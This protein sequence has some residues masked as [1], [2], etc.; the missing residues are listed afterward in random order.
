MAL[1]HPL[2]DDPIF[3]TIG[4]M[5]ASMGAEAYVIGGFVRDFY[6]RRPCKDIDIVVTGSGIALAELLGQKLGVN[7]SVFKNFGTAM[8]H[9][10]DKELEF[11]GARKESY[12][13]DSRKPIV[14]D[15]T[16]EDDQNRRDFTVNAMAFSLQ[17]A[18]FGRLV[19]PFNGLEDLAEC[20]IRTPL[21]PDT[22]FSDDPL[23]MIRAV[24]FCSQ[25]GFYIAEEA[26]ESIRRNASRLEIISKERI[27]TELDKILLCPKPSK[28]FFLFDKC[29]L[30][31]HIMPELVALKG[32]DKVG[33]R[34]HKDNFIHTLKVVDNVA[35]AGG[36]LSLRWAALLHDIAKPRTKAYDELVGWSFHGH[37]VVGA[38]MVGTIFKRMKMPLGAMLKFV[39]KM[40]LLHLR[41]IVLAEDVVS[42]SAVRRLLFE[43]GDDI[44]QLML[45]C[46]ADITSANDAKVERFLHNF[47]MVEQ[48]LKDI[49]VKDHVRN[50]Q[51]PIAGELIMELYSIDP[52]REVGLIKNAIK[53]A[54]L[55]GTIENDYSQ[56][57]SFM[58]K[59]AAEILP[60]EAIAFFNSKQI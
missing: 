26:M 9:Y 38:R 42:D 1:N 15:G 7:V 48:K 6:L 19:D 13:R 52:C 22:T 47:D 20:I 58:Q 49:E 43:A 3:K 5:A 46:R 23:R 21:D 28:G 27:V 50:F 36:S 34:A 12:S 44:D 2:C 18:D 55:D 25:L 53:E 40:V 10:G 4:Q 51:P 57:Y 35:E 33:G 30:L 8:L 16:L 45:L 41:P 37:E 59:I 31:G 11:V 17:E 24:R 14:E 29:G 54:I 39:E 60:K 32:V 56:A